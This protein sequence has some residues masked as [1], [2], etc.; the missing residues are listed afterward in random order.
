[1]GIND[2]NADEYVEAADDDESIK[3]SVKD[4]EGNINYLFEGLVSNISIDAVMM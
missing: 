2:E 1:M 4:N 3:V